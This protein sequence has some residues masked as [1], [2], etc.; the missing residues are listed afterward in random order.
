MILTAHGGAEGTGRN[1]MR[2]FN[3]IFQHKINAIEVDVRKSGRLLYISHMRTF[4]PKKAI[5]LTYVF[6]YVKEHNLKV[7]CDLKNRRIIGEVIALAKSMQ[8]LTNLI[9]TGAIYP[10][11]LPNITAGDVYVNNCFYFPL[12]PNID[13]ITKIKKILDDTNNKHIIGLNIQY[14]YATDEFIKKAK[15][16]NLPLSVY[17]LDSD[18]E[19]RRI[20]PYDVANI[21]TNTVISALNIMEELK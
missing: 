11:D 7:N 5:P 13:N 3:E 12:A 6:E 18:S 19:L 21:T 8:V 10:K 16:L 17:T 15:E 4:F 9:F 1:S 20:I 14:R 2:Y